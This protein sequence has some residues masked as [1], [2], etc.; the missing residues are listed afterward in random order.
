[1]STCVCV[2]VYVSVFVCLQRLV[3]LITLNCLSIDGICCHCHSTSVC[4]Y[5]YMSVCVYVYM[6]VCMSTEAGED[7]YVIACLLM[8]FVAVAI[9]RLAR[10]DNT[11]F[12]ASL[13]G[14]KS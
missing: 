10:N 14:Y 11:S 1:M 8:V 5:V 13:E 3:K 4:V 6:S 7:D 2:C 9:P 12:K